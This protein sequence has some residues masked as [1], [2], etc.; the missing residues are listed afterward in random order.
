MPP[1]PPPPPPPLPQDANGAPPPPLPP[2]A[3]T[4]PVGSTVI[5]VLANT[6]RQPPPP[7]PPPPLG[8]LTQPSD[9]GS[10]SVAM[11]P[12]PPP[13]LPP[14]GNGSSPLTARLRNT[15]KPVPK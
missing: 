1:E 10:A 6:I 12:P 2:L 9:T 11:L 4:W 5:D 13:P 8:S 15:S 3:E 14:I 7:P